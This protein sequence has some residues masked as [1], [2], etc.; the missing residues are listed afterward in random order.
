MSCNDADDSSKW[1][2]S[3]CS[4]LNWSKSIKCTICLTPNSA[5]KYIIDEVK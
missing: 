4:Y 3:Q 2:C 1:S 5:A